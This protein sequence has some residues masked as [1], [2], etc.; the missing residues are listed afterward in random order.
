[1]KP[2][3]GRLAALLL[4]A[5]GVAD[6]P[7]QE[8]PAP[9]RE[10][11]ILRLP[12]AK[13]KPVIDGVMSE[14]EWI[15]T[16]H[17]FG[18]I[19]EAN[20]GISRRWVDFWFG[21]DDD[22]IYFAQ[23]S[24]LPPKTM[25][26]SDR[27]E[28]AIQ[29]RFPGSPVR[30]VSFN[31]KGAGKLPEGTKVV[32]KQEGKFWISE[33][34]IPLKSLGVKAIPYG[35]K[36][37]LQMTRKFVDQDE[38]ASWHRS[39][40]RHPDGIWVPE[41]DIP[42]VSFRTL[43]THL[44]R[45][46]I[47]HRPTW[48]IDNRTARPRKVLC[49]SEVTCK[50]A[51]PHR[52]TATLEVAP[53]HSEAWVTSGIWE[54]T[55]PRELWAEMVDAETGKVYFRRS[56]R[57]HV[58][59][60]LKWVDP[61]P[62]Y[63]LQIG[64]FPSYKRL[65]FLLTSGNRTKLKKLR[66]QQFTLRGEDGKE[67]T[68]FTPKLRADGWFYDGHLPDLP[69]GTYHIV[70]EFKDPKGKAEKL[71]DHFAVKHFEWE[72]LGLGKDRIVIPPFKPLQAKDGEI[73]ALLT[74]FKEAPNG[75]WEAI[76]A[77]DENILAKP[78][79]FV[80]DGK[81]F[82]TVAVREIETSPDLVIRETDLRYKEL[83]L[84][85]RREYEQDGFC[86]ITLKF[87]P[88]KPF[89]ITTLDLNIPLKKSVARYFTVFDNRARFST[90]RKLPDQPGTVLKS[91]DGGKSFQFPYLKGF[92]P[93]FWLGGFRKG[94][95]FCCEAPHCWGRKPGTASQEITVDE[96]AVRLRLHL[97]AIPRVYKKGESIVTAFQPTPVKPRPA[98]GAEYLHA[99]PFGIAD[100]LTDEEV[101][102]QLPPPGARYYY[103]APRWYLFARYRDGV[104]SVPNDDWSFV[105]MAREGKWK[106][107]DEVKNFLQQYFKRNDLNP[108]AFS[109]KNPNSWMANC[110]MEKYMLAF[111]QGARNNTFV[112]PYG[113]PRELMTEWPEFEVYGDEW[114]K[115]PWRERRNSSYAAEPSPTYSD[116]LLYNIRAR[117]REGVIDG[118]YYDMI[119][120][121]Q[122]D[123]PFVS[124][125]Q[126]LANGTIRAAWGIFA[127]RELVKRTAIMMYQ[128]KKDFCGYAPLMLHM[129]GAPF[130]PVLSFAGM[131]LDWEM[132]FS[133]MVYQKRF[134]TEYA[135][136]H[137][138]GEQAGVFATGLLNFRGVPDEDLERVMRSAV[139]TSFVY[140]V[141]PSFKQS[142]PK[143]YRPMLDKIYEF[144]YGKL[145]TTVIPAFAPENPVTVTPDRVKATV[146]KRADGAL[147]LR[148]GNLGE[149]AEAEFDL[150]GLA[151]G[152]ATDLMTGKKLGSGGRFKLSI[153]D[154]DFA[155]VEVLP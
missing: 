27:N 70:A 53:R 113:N 79:E 137:S 93:Y 58:G 54:T 151:K 57:F 97:A 51:P 33:A 85:V 133:N 86:K 129:T 125:A 50:T 98:R 80:I 99:R 55:T 91:S 75:F 30:T 72:N 82:E 135:I 40:E 119:T 76:Y 121:Y 24:V 92:Y 108:N 109:S 126:E 118:Y 103:V 107:N 20:G 68:R 16:S 34:A 141:D 17:Q 128:E 83:K 77:Q 69:E 114:R 101:A 63:R 13:R 23:R 59:G 81:P 152:E 149:A 155:L 45:P 19:S 49:R 140:H 12:P 96:D 132:N 6:L 154:H 136:T 73:K 100:L 14:G 115:S 37:G 150:H 130:V 89:R 41:K 46:G 36:C 148:I 122:L 56:F 62:P 134:P 8:A 106:S 87:D 4:L 142:A 42:G 104:C 32:G 105:R 71:S 78:V 64:V 117:L 66:D 74:G 138:T 94:L 43:W 48:V 146:A 9:D 39:T 15:N 10:A 35:Q 61:D 67:I 143:W 111:A 95:S 84:T 139:A 18:A 110:P 47:S 116:F 11:T 153:A 131:Q 28:A 5:A 29:L 144:G 52:E 123:N 38:I 2:L 145:D 127:L 1:M 120:A 25:E 7:A 31:P 44:A 124:E 21:Y 147:L 22:N 65:R 88:E 102:K 90:N 112:I 26:F 3:Y 60:S